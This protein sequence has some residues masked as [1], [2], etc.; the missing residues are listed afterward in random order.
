M[1]VAFTI[2]VPVESRFLDLISDVAGKYAELAG[3]TT[4]DAQAL[5][6]SIATEVERLANGRGG[7]SAVEL[8]FEAEAGGVDVTLRCDGDSATVKQA[9]PARKT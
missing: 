7:A 5:A 6:S 8:V 2:S 3:G 9:L 1:P 4:T